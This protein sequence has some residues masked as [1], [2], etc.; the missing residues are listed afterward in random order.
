MAQQPKKVL[1]LAG[2]FGI[3]ILSMT[4]P[5]RETYT[6]YASSALNRHCNN[7]ICDW[8]MTIWGGKVRELID[9]N[10]ERYNLVLFSIYRSQLIDN[11]EIVTL[12]ILGNFVTF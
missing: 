1:A 12:A 10:T 5:D 2:L 7:L 11:Q 6:K 3:G 4:N 9:Q 8:G